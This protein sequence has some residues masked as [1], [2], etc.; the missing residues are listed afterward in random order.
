MKITCS[1]G[2]TKSY[3]FEVTTSNCNDI[4]LPEL[5]QVLPFMQ[6]AGLIRGQQRR[7]AP[8]RSPRA[9]F[10]RQK[11]LAFSINEFFTAIADALPAHVLIASMTIL[12]SCQNRRYY[13][14]PE[15]FH[16]IASFKE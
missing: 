13:S 4:C 8:Y 1:H 2:Y 16:Q 6:R 11:G 9:I 14:F 5:R 7:L 15:C 3:A 10:S 12:I